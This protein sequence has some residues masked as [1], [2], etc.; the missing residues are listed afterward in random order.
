VY[1][2]GSSRADRAD[3]IGS[4]MPRRRA[5]VDITAVSPP[6]AVLESVARPT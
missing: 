1:A 2:A 6:V 5:P 4:T 3:E